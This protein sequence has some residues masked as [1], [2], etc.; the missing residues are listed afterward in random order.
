[1]PMPG[2]LTVLGTVISD[3]LL[4]VADPRIRLTDRSE[5]GERSLRQ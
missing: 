5:G 4:V 3:I 1:M 2:S